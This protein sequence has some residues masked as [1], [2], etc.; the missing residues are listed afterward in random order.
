MLACAV[1]LTGPF[2]AYAAGPRTALDGNCPVCLVKMDKIVKGDPKISSVYDG[3]TY[4]FPS[5]EQ[6]RMFDANPTAY[7]P[8]AGGDC[9]VC[10]VEAGKTVRGKP[11]I[12]AVHDGRLFLF[13][14]E[15]QKRMFEGNPKKYAEADL[16]LAGNCAVCLAK[17]DKLMPGKPEYVSVYDGRRYLFPG[18]EQ[19]RTFDADPAGFA[20]AMGGNCTVCK[21]EM[22][23][24]VQGKAQ[25]HLAHNG[26]L[27]LFPSK[28]QLEMFKASPEKYEN[29]DLAHGG[30]CVVCKVEMGKDVKGKPGY[31]VDY[32]G[33]RYLFPGQ[34]QLEMFRSNPTKYHVKG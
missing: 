1:V 17:A 32:K 6:K 22:R 29:A 27:Y 11:Q 28:K 24:E 12:H 26:R 21:V 30:N 3:K 13:P 18:P 4:L 25:F 2:Y 23:K 31:A 8:A 20:P 10:R 19:K 34:K 7:V 33:K 14:S 9:V 15:K 16:A 5:K